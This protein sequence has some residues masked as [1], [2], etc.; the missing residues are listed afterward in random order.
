MRAGDLFRSLPIRFQLR[1][2][3]VQIINQ[4]TTSST[5]SATINGHTGRGRRADGHSSAQ[6]EAA[7]AARAAKITPC[8]SR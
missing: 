2:R 6:R 4:N 7:D 5:A 1:Y 3:G 8:T